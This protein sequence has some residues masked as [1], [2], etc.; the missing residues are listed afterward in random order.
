MIVSKDTTR[1]YGFGVMVIS[2]TFYIIDWYY[3]Y[4]IMFLK[5]DNIIFTIFTL[6]TRLFETNRSICC[7]GA[8]YVLEAKLETGEE[9]P[10]NEKK[11][12]RYIP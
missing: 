7:L 1:M 5:I 6:F 8:W 9:A 4:F 10:W 12:D 11:K 2:D 3:T